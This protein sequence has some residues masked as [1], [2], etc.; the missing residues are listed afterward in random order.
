[1][2]RPVPVSLL[3]LSC[4]LQTSFASAWSLTGRASLFANEAKDHGQSDSSQAQSS[5]DQQSLRLMLENI[6]D[7][8]EIVLHGRVQRRHFSSTPTDKSLAPELFRLGADSLKWQESQWTTN[9]Q[10]GA[11]TQISGD[12]DRLFYRHHQS[13]MSWTIGR[14]ALDWGVGRFWQPM[15]L[16]GA[17]APTELDTDFKTGVDALSVDWYPSLFSTLTFVWAAQSSKIQPSKISP[18]KVPSHEQNILLHYRAQ[19]SDASEIGLM[20]GNILGDPVIAASFE[21]DWQGIGW[22]LE[23]QQKHKDALG[24][25]LWWIA[26]FDTQFEDGTLLTLEWHD[27][28]FGAQHTSDISQRLTDPGLVSALEPHM[29]RHVLGLSLQH[30]L[31][32]LWQ[33]GYSLFA[34]MLDT[35]PSYLHQLHVTRSLSNEADLTLTLL[36]ATGQASQNGLPQSEFGSVPDSISL[37]LRGYF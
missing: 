26:G 22:R 10:N 37:R 25:R 20:A 17:F 13:Q 19:A 5:Q 3:L 11:C 12:I 21:T 23:A 34:A 35:N 28:A 8:N 29:V 32:P 30:T 9:C 15:N 2:T 33:G 18:S 31:S 4:L 16:L 24:N 1:M 7:N 27:N 14:Q 6:T 36:H